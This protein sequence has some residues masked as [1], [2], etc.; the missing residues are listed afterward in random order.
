[1][2]Q[3]KIAIGWKG[4]E[5]PDL[6]LPSLPEYIDVEIVRSPT[7]LINKLNNGDVDAIVRGNL[8]SH[9]VIPKLRRKFH[10]KARRLL[11][12]MV[13]G[14]LI[15]MGPVGIDDVDEDD[16]HSMADYAHQ[17][18]KFM[19]THKEMLTQ[20]SGRT[21]KRKDQV[22][23]LIAY[24]RQEDKGRNKDVDRS[25]EFMDKVKD[26]LWGSTTGI[27][28]IGPDVL[29]DDALM[30]SDLTIFPNGYTGNLIFRTLFYSYSS[31]SYGGPVVDLPDGK[32]YID[33]SRGRKD[34]Y[35]PIIMAY[36]LV[37]SHRG[38]YNEH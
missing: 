10:C 24:G 31:L 23:H 32:Y 20:I 5:E 8:E 21:E 33:T 7:A 28:I 3:V 16:P 25:L 4:T 35:M 37:L 6:G 17:C 9:K 19:Q 2:E 27:Q 18:C 22:V 36:M 30:D 26:R 38:M 34:Y 29:L 15:A 13:S 1:M 11:F 14:K 12:T